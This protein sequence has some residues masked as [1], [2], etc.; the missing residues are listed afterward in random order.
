MTSHG[1]DPSDHAHPPERLAP[2]YRRALHLEA[3]GASEAVMAEKLGVA[4]ESIPT[5][6]RIAH[7]KAEVARRDLDSDADPGPG[8]GPGST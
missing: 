4:A 6:L 8:P 2:V 7:A 3:A 1:D 5:L